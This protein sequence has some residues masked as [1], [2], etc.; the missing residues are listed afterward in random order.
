MSKVNSPCV[1][2]SAAKNQ[3][4]DSLRK[5]LTDFVAQEIA[6]KKIREANGRQ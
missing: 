3:N 4:I 2:I 1:F 6:G 5:L